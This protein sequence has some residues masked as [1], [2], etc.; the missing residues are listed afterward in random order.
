M[1]RIVVTGG[2]GKLGRACVQ[3]LI[4]HGY[5]VINADIAAPKESRCPFFKIDLENMAQVSELLSAM[6]FEH[7]RGIDA[8]V[9]LAAIPGPGSAPNETV[10]RVNTVST[11]NVFEAARRLRVKNIV[12]ASSETL[13]GLPFDEPPPYV[14]VDEECEP[15]PNTGYSLSKLMGEEMAKQFCRWDPEQKIVG[16]RFSNVMEPSDYAAFPA[17]DNNPG[18]R[19]FNLWGYIDARDGAQAIRKALEASL[20]GAYVFIIA[21]ADTVL[22]RANEELLS[23]F[24][25]N[26]PI[27]RAFGPN[28]TLLSI[29]KARSILGYVPQHSWRSTR[30]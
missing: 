8:I 19:R 28:E 9:H 15:R 1:K 6:D 18:G 13:L 23:G 26:V 5:E 11:Y 22:T 25:P 29:E 24:Y 12:W 21:N 16:L 27:K 7:T 14:P 3:D 4:E 30:S 10:F 17:F 2:S 20:K